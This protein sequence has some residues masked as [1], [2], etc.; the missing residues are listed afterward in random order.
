MASSEHV[1]A[2]SGLR[3]MPNLYELQLADD[4]ETEYDYCDDDS[5]LRHRNGSDSRTVRSLSMENMYSDDDLEK[6]DAGSPPYFGQ[7]CVMRH[8]VMGR[9]GRE[10]Y[11]PSEG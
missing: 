1:D 7:S 11:K 2:G 5:K 8:D 4:E 9:T 10:I 3:N 6:G